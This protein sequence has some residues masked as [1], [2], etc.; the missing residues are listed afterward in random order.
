MRLVPVSAM[1]SPEPLF[2][3]RASKAGCW[4]RAPQVHTLPAHARLLESA[5]GGP[6]AAPVPAPA[7][8]ATTR[9]PRRCWRCRGTG[10]GAGGA[11]SPLLADARGDLAA[12]LELLAALLR[13]APAAARCGGPPCEPAVPLPVRGRCWER[14]YGV[15]PAAAR[16]R[17]VR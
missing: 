8:G 10:A 7:G 6:D 9:A 11:G 4:D 5:D 15:W 12:A 17:L 16:R 3:E 1:R 13:V 14:R 2:S